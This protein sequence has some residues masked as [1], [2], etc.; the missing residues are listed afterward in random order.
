MY[1]PIH[2]EAWAGPN[3]QG[4]TAYTHFTDSYYGRNLSNALVS[5]SF[6]LS[7]ALHGKEQLDISV[8]RN[9]DT[10]YAD[11]DQ[12]SRNDSSCQIFVQTYYAVNGST[13]CH[14]TPKFTCHRL[15]T[16]TGLPWSYST[17]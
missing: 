14:N 3:C 17:E 16:N 11:K 9:F 13:A 10:W 4:E 8:T 15:W 12:L 7:R 1:G 5:R 2:L 6:K